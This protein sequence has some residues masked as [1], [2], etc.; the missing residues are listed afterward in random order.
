MRKLPGFTDVNSDQQNNGL[1]ASL[2]MTVRRQRGWHFGASVDDTLY[3]AFGQRQ[4]STMFTV[5]ESV[6]RGYG[7]GPPILAR[8]GRVERHL[9]SAQQAVA[10][11]VNVSVDSRTGKTV[12][13][14]QAS[15]LLHRRRHLFRLFRRQRPGTTPDRYALFLPRLLLHHHARSRGTCDSQ[16]TPAPTRLLPRRDPVPPPASATVAATLSISPRLTNYYWP[17]LGG[18]FQVSPTP[19]GRLRRAIA[20]ATPS[21][22]SSKSSSAA[23]ATRRRLLHRRRSR[24]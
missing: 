7:G 18:S 21:A 13:R 2:V 16:V 12:L 24:R 17:S 22:N 15:Q 3:D 20:Q 1:Q 23:V 14:P 5:A 8:P 9:H 19:T 4:V 10:D 6:S 11:T